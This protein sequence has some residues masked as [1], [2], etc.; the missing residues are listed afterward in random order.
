MDLCFTPATALAA[1]IARRDLS[2]REATDAVLDRIAATEPRLNAF[3]TVC[4]ERARA[5]ADAVDAR[6]AKGETPGPL[7]GVPFSVKDLV[8]TAEVRTTFGSAAFEHNVPKA[9]AVAVARLRAAGAILVGKTSTPEFGHKPITYTPLFGWTANPWDASRTPGGSS[10]GA[11]A[12]VAAGCGP[13]GLGTDGGGSIRIPAAC[14]GIVGMKATLGRVPHDQTPDVFNNLAYFGPMTR[15]VDDAALMLSVMA[16]A[17]PSDPHALRLPPFEV[18]AR[19]DRLDGLK[20]AW[21]PRL[22]NKVVAA[23]V[24]A[25]TEAAVKELEAAGATV[26]LLEEA[27]ENSEPMWRVMTFAAWAARFGVH[28]QKFGNRMDPTL[29]ES[30]ERGRSFGA[31]DLQHAM[32]FRSSLYKRV[33]GWFARFDAL[34]TPTLSR[35]AV[36]QKQELFGPFEIDGQRCESLRADWYPYTHPFNLTGHPTITLPCGFGTDGLPIG[37]QI[38]GPWDADALLLQ[39]AGLLEQ[40]RPWADR[41]PPL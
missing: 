30:M 36:D 12:S 41:R 32:G 37:L 2:A 21:A 7:A 3:F 39:I 18:P 38:V 10:G 4:A 16:G 40:R 1:A 14:C 33:A 22:G 6:Q 34:V 27:F 19:R 17:D 24:L 9:D 29:V 11:A 13:L 23:D 20:L 31:V 35:T 8:N 26:E 28:L 15:T 5:E 25:E